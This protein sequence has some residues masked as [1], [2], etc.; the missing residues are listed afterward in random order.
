MIYILFPIFFL[1]IFL[2]LLFIQKT[3]IARFFD[4]AAS[5]KRAEFKNIASCEVIKSGQ[6]N[7]FNYAQTCDL[8][9]FKDFAAIVRR[10]HFFKNSFY[11]P[12][13]IAKEHKNDSE[14]SSFGKFHLMDSQLTKNELILSLV[15]KK[16]G[17]HTIELTLVHPPEEV[18]EEFKQLKYPVS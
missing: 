2:I 10:N 6:K 14:F 18:P 3:R 16:L 4:K 11:T 1:I 8:Y 12:Y 7:Y 5:E 17:S 9:F 13:L 15:N